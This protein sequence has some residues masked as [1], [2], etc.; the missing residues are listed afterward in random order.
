MAHGHKP[1]TPKGQG[2]MAKPNTQKPATS[3]KPRGGSS[4]AKSTVKFGHRPK[5]M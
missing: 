4:A 1:D 3:G 2:G 5:P